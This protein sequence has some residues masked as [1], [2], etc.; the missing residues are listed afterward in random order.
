MAEPDARRGLPD[1]WPLVSETVAFEAVHELLWE[2]GL[3]DGLPMVPPTAERLAAMLA[4]HPEPE[5]SLGFMP[6][7]F[8]D[9]T[10]AAVAYNCVLAGCRPQELALVATAAAACLEPDFNL[11]GIATTTGSAAIGMIVH[12]PVVQRL[13]INASINC[14]GPGTRTNA[15]IGRALSLVLRNVGGARSESGDMATLGQPA[16]FG[17][18]FGEYAETD[19]P[20]LHARRG[21]ETGEDA[22]TVIGI[23]GTAEILPSDGRDTPEAI[24]E[25]IAISMRAAFLTNGACKQPQLP[26]HI[27]VLP[28]E[29]A[30][31]IRAQGW[32][33]PRI[34]RFLLEASAHEGAPIAACA[35]DIQPVVTGGPGVKMAHLP[36]WG[37]GSRSVTVRLDAQ[38]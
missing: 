7:L 9:L 1:E 29:L 6:P 37:G 19:I 32:D 5:R 15:A 8:G 24:L 13:G 28:P 2:Q 12:G 14:L 11:L 26:E 21:I 33:L 16:K 4:G 34:Q 18:C 17:L 30:G 3:S 27:F 38:F 25:T 10:I 31:Q 35:E 36:L 22:V 23:S 20:R